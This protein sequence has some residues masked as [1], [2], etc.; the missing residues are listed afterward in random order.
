M[1]C[2]SQSFVDVNFPALVTFFYWTE[3]RLPEKS[4]LIG[5]LLQ[6]CRVFQHIEKLVILAA[7]VHRKLFDAPR[8]SG[9]VFNDYFNFYLPK[10]GTSSSSIC[11]DKVCVFPL[12]SNVLLEQS[13][14]THD[15]EPKFHSSNWPSIVGWSLSFEVVPYECV[16]ETV[17]Q[18]WGCLSL[19]PVDL[20]ED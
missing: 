15:L 10:M 7:S 19:R 4:E 3:N 6:L 12:F 13:C 1:K 9:A 20:F 5:D 16:L 11:Y 17:T 8:L 2:P 18:N 14:R